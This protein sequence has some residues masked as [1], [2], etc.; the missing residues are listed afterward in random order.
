MLRQTLTA[1]AYHGPDAKKHLP[2]NE[3]WIE[4]QQ[5][6]GHD[7][8]VWLGPDPE[9][10]SI[11]GKSFRIEVSTDPFQLFLMG[12]IFN[13]CLS[14]NDCNDMSM[15]ANT[16]DANKQVIYV[17]NDS[18]QIVARKLIAISRE[19][20]LVGYNFYMQSSFLDEP[21]CEQLK[22]EVTSYCQRLADR[23]GIKLADTGIPI[24]LGHFWYDDGNVDWNATH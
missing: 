13:T 3:T 1:Y 10:I 5:R 4:K 16:A 8:D 14:P 15:L 21:G 6:I 20:G 22:K 9:Q 12:T 7:V 2:F 17:R 19:N 24:G 11:G 23:V 18:G